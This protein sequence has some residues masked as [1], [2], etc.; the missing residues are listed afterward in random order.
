M[1]TDVM[2]K[3]KNKWKEETGRK[4]LFTE[5]YDTKIK[6]VKSNCLECLR[7]KKRKC[8]D[9]VNSQTMDFIV[10]G[11]P[12]GY[13]QILHIFRKHL[14]NLWKEIIQDF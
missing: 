14:T 6:D 1:R 4:L 2:D 5:K 11:G 9:S 7:H 3:K 13:C 12:C 8:W 10:T